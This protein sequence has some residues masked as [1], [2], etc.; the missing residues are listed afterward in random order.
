MTQFCSKCGASLPEQARFCSQCGAEALP[1][2]GEQAISAAVGGDV[3]G[4]MN[5]A[6]RDVHVHR[7]GDEHQLVT[8]KVCGGTGEVEIRVTCPDCNGSG[9]REGGK[10]FC[11]RCGGHQEM[12]P[13][14][15]PEVDWDAVRK[16]AE[17]E[18]EREIRSCEASIQG[19]KHILK[20]APH[21][22]FPDADERAFD[23][24]LQASLKE[25]EQRLR[26]L[27]RSRESFIQERVEARR[28][29]YLSYPTEQ[30]VYVRGSG[31]LPRT[32]VCEHCNGQG[33]VRV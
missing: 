13:V 33:Q 29:Q 4:E 19:N 14:A 20:T 18:Y 26:E 5:I 23:K 10:I 16:S 21:R 8:C 6:G 28:Q 22:L 25:E 1:A 3:E 17:D 32:V 2:A 30:R 12:R 9:M 7:Y 11:A 15:R 31:T 27:K 24:G